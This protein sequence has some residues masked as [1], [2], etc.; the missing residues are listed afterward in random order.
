MPGLGPAGWA[1][2]APALAAPAPAPTPP[3]VSSRAWIGRLVVG[4]PAVIVVA[5]FAAVTIVPFV[6][7]WEAFIVTSASMTPTIPVGSVVVVDP[8]AAQSMKVGDIGTFVA[9]ESGLRVTHRVVEVQGAE[10]ASRV[11]ITKGDAVR[12]PDGPR[13]ASTAIGRVQYTVPWVGYVATAVNE[14]QVR[15]PLIGLVAV[16][17]GVSYW[18]SRRGGAM[19]MPVVPV[20]AQ[21]VAQAQAPGAPAYAPNPYTPNQFAPP[22]AYPQGAPGYPQGAPGMPAGGPGQPGWV[23]SNVATYG[24]GGPVMPQ[25]P[26]PRRLVDRVTDWLV[27]GIGVVAIGLATLVFVPLA[28]DLR[29]IPVSDSTMAP[30]VPF[31]ALVFAERTQVQTLAV[32]DLVVYAPAQEQGRVYVRR[33][34]ALDKSGATAADYKMTPKADQLPGPDNYTIAGN[35]T[36]GKVRYV[37]PVAGWILGA[38]GQREGLLFFGA[39]ILLLVVLR[40]VRR[41]RP[42]RVTYP[43]PMVTP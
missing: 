1:P 37:V 2:P 31:G 11:Y 29:P 30:A 35:Q 24:Q 3:P 26:R 41:P 4:I 36:V 32:G 9:P 12:N 6:L 21:Y 13:G 19:A 15:W 38:A 28:I 25:A 22:P 27:I 16:L 33:V 7:R 42:A 40:Q 10:G 5:I 39:L 23:G 8:T 18:R 20:G 14:P 34:Q 17:L 43:M